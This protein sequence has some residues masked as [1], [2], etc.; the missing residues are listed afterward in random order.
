SCAL[1][2]LSYEEER[3]SIV[4]DFINPLLAGL[5]LFMKFSLGLSAIA[6]IAALAIVRVFTRQKNAWRSALIMFAT[7]LATTIVIAIPYCKSPKNFL[8]WLVVSWHMADGYSIAM[9]L[10]GGPHVVAWA[11]I[12][13]TAY[14]AFFILLRS[15]KS[16]LFY[17]A[18]AFAIAIFLCFKHSYVRQDAEHILY[19]FPFLL[20][21]VGI[22]GL[23]SHGAREFRFAAYCY[24]I[25]FI[26]ALPNAK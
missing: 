12:A 6:M 20:S 16:S 26:L 11:L 8:A 4:A 14:L 25:I 9:S 3:L 18:V 5:F 22:L 21:L 24:V 7:L 2:A 13:M 10:L 19:F 1:S 23:N 17:L 15:V